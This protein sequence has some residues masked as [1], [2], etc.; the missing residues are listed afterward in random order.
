MCIFLENLFNNASIK[1]AVFY[2]SFLSCL[3]DKLHH[4]YYKLNNVYISL[5]LEGHQNVR[6]S[7]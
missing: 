4:Y 1:I 3:L 6:D 7:L 2:E 5:D